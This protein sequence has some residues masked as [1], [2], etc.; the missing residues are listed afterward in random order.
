MR[1]QGF[2]RQPVRREVT[3]SQARVVRLVETP[4][5]SLQ[6][7]RTVPD[8]R[9][10]DLKQRHL[11]RALEVGRFQGDGDGTGEASQILTGPYH[12]KSVSAL[13][14]GFRKS[15]CR[16]ETSFGLSESR[17]RH[18]LETD[19]GLGGLE[20]IKPVSWPVDRTRENPSWLDSWFESPEW[21]QHLIETQMKLALRP[22]DTLSGMATEHLWR[23][24]P[25]PGGQLTV[26]QAWAEVPSAFRELCRKALTGIVEQAPLPRGVGVFLV[27]VGALA[28]E[29]LIAKFV[30]APGALLLQGVEVLSLL[31]PGGDPRSYAGTDLVK[32]WTNEAIQRSL[33]QHLQQWSGAIPVAGSVGLSL[34]AI[35]MEARKPHRVPRRDDRILL[36]IRD[37]S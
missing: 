25:G 24:D 8:I 12:F 9:T 18:P 35:G 23:L 4:Y 31:L 19:T 21:L 29:L 16:V 5:Q 17:S 7:H 1:L 28:G 30:V 37:G 2:E 27:E 13:R 34:I 15:A 32:R 33:N 20:R 26:S 14:S 22:V 6:L 3:D 36:R 10:D 11:Q